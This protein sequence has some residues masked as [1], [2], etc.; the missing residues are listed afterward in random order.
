MLERQI[1]GLRRHA[2]A[3]RVDE[4]LAA[5]CFHNLD[6]GGIVYRGRQTVVVFECQ[7]LN[8]FNLGILRFQNKAN[9]EVRY[10][11]ERHGVGTSC[12]E[13]FLTSF[14]PKTNINNNSSIIHTY[15]Q[16]RVC[17]FER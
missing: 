12:R 10:K 11:V 16:L 8:T 7:K 13:N 1:S 15:R 5:S 2:L 3:K 6:I 14:F 4:P 17:S 9:L